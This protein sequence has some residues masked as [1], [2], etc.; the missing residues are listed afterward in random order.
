MVAYDHEFKIDLTKLSDKRL[1][2][3]R[4]NLVSGLFNGYDG[5]IDNIEKR[6]L[7]QEIDIERERRYKR[8]AETRSNLALLISV[9]ALG[10]S[11]IVAI[12]KNGS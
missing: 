4:L 10:I 11:I 12:F 2:E 6:A 3:R 1:Q 5:S 7:I 9:T 8:A